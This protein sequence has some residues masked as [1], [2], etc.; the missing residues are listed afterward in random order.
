M[1]KHP[2]SDEVAAALGA[3]VTGGL[4]PTHTKLTGAFTRAGYGR[5]STYDGTSEDLRA[6][7]N[8]ETR[9]RETVTAA[10]RDP[11]RARELVDSILVEFRAHGF[12][13][14]SSSEA[15]EAERV[16]KV[17]TLQRAFSRIDWELDDEGVLRPAG[18]GVVGSVS[19]RQAIEDQ[20]DRLRRA[21][22]DPALLLGTAKEMLESTA[23]FVLEFFA[24]PYTTRSTFDELWYHARDRL[25]LLPEQVDVSAPGGAQVKAM[26]GASWVIAKTANEIRNIEGTGHGR[27]LPTG[28]TPEMAL[29]VVRESCSIAEL[30]LA[31]LDRMAGR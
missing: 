14:A 1:A 16:A 6:K 13:S 4:G 31:S 21:T 20:L 19:G 30:V 23:K 2:A 9:V 28:V 7:P 3:F 12:F 18:V 10:A 15:D 17:R 25:G 24:V 27:T 29:L 26:L 22:D 8:K 5:V 11:H